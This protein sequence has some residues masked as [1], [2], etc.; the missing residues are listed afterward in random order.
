[1]LKKYLSEGKIEQVITKLEELS[2]QLDADLQSEIIMQ[3][4]RF[5]TFARERRNGILSEEQQSGQLA[6]MNLALLEIIDHI[7][8]TLT[9][10]GRKKRASVWKWAI[11]VVAVV[12]ISVAG[13]LYLHKIHNVVTGDQAP[14]VTEEPIKQSLPPKEDTTAREQP[15]ASTPKTIRTEPKPGAKIEQTTHG[16]RSP[17]VIGK[18]VIINYGDIKDMSTP[19][20]DTT[21]N[22]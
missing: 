22:N 17:A 8:E 7:P 14:V 18:D 10:D 9:G 5:R 1:M 16:D 15:A 20:A 2:P 21:K 11:V 19:K 12:L 13:Y 3:A 4:S 6:K